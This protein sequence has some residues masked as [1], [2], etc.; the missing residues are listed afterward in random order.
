MRRIAV[1]AFNLGGPDRPEAVEP[2]LRNLFSD[3]F[4]LRVPWL[5][6]ICLAWFIAR[7]RSRIA[8]GIYDQIGGGSP[9]LEETRKQA[10]ALER[11]LSDSQ[12]SYRVFVAMR[13]W[14]PMAEEVAFD[15]ADW[16]PDCTVLL[17][18]YP[19]FSTTT[20]QSF[21][22]AWKRSA[23]VAGLAVPE[24]V[25]CCWPELAG[26][27]NAMARRISDALERLPEGTRT[28]ILF[29][30][31]GLPRKFVEDGDPYADRV[32]RSVAAIVARLPAPAPD[33]VICYQSRVGRLEWLRPYAE[34][35]IREAGAE[36]LSLVVVPV[37]FVSEHSE[38]LVELDIDYAEIAASCGVPH[39]LRVP[40]V[41]DDPLFIAGLAGMV[42]RIAGPGVTA[43]GAACGPDFGC[44]PAGAVGT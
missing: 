23:G 30:A 35:E 24:S 1:I 32:A 27:A 19:Q 36:G 18:L 44:C 40:V 9:I 28:R 11:E 34:D 26:F 7:R 37:S 8:A 15:V 20:T 21:L 43:E 3:P 10:E 5:V 33:H 13:H 25:I 16:Q 12:E 14:H 29:S 6:R 38:T 31:H 17:P 42:R 41:G 4:I 22:G 39:Y 2:F